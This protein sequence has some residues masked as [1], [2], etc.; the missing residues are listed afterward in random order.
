MVARGWVATPLAP[1]MVGL[2]AVVPAG[3]ALDPPNAGAWTIARACT[4]LSHPRQV[5]LTSKPTRIARR[6]HRAVARS[7]YL[8]PTFGAASKCYS[9]ARRG[10]L[11]SPATVR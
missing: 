8:D 11:L 3:Q 4:P 1:V 2:V 10:R 6:G 7:T 5:V 9:T